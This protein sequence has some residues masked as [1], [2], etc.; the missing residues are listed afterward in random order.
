MDAFI[1]WSGG[2][3]CCMA[4]HTLRETKALDVRFLFTTL[5]RE[6]QRI[7]MH[8]VRREL[9]TR[10]AMALGI[11]SRKLY[12]PESPDMSTYE[13]FMKHEMQLMK[14]RG[15]EDAVF[16][17]LFLED[18]RRYRE[19]KMNDLGMRAHFPVWGINTTELLKRFIGLGY[20]A[21]VV[22][23]NH[24]HLDSSFLG[25]TLDLDFMN[26]LPSTVDPCG[27]NGEFHTFVYEG[28]L[29]AHPLAIKAGEKVEKTYTHDGKEFSYGF[30]DLSLES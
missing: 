13:Q 18:L 2:K 20:K 4:L 17:D 22:S 5:S 11:P 26:D 3:D 16:G 8:G 12:L 7:S 21:I 19:T 15:I 24:Q 27:E 30:I 6:H 29:F 28:P 1:N 14:Q 10:Q 25:R 9:L 23:V